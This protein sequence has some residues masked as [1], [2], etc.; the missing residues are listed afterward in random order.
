ML[1]QENSNIHPSIK[2]ENMYLEWKNDMCL[3]LWGSCV[4]ADNTP[5]CLLFFNL[6]QGVSP[7]PDLAGFTT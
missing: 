3:F 5:A 1:F 7:N 4:W 6:S 2:Y